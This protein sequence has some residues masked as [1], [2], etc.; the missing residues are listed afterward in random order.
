LYEESQENYL[1]YAQAQ[2]LSMSDDTAKL[3]DSEIRTLVEGGH[4][5]ATMLL[6]KHIKQLHTLAEALLE[7]ETLT[8]D[9]I[10]AL[11]NDGERPDRKEPRHDA[12]K[13]LGKSG[14]SVPKTRKR[15]GLGGP[16]A[17]GA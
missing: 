8:G 9:E 3:I 17:A 12:P 11:L 5:K 13:S 2:R 1:G 15:S 10:K 4:A 7:Y 16:A 6:K 14:S